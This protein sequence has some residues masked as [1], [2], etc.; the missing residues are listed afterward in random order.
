MKR[1]LIII[2][3]LVGI[4][5]MADA[6]LK[7]KDLE[8]TLTILQAELEQYNNEL[9]RRS[10]MRKERTK[11]LITQLLLTMKQADQNAL[12]LYSQYQENVF[13]MTY[14][15]HEATKLYRDFHKRQIPFTE[16]LEKNGREL[17]RYD[18][19]ISRLEALPEI[20]TTK[21]GTSKRDSCLVL[22]KRIRRMLGESLQATKVL[23][24]KLSAET[25]ANW[26][27]EAI[28]RFMGEGAKEQLYT[29][30]AIQYKQATPGGPYQRSISI[31][32]DP[33]DEPYIAY[34]TNEVCTAVGISN[35]TKA[36]IAQE[37]DTVVKHLMKEA[38]PDGTKG[39]VHIE[40]HTKDDQLQFEITA[41][42]K[43]T[44]ITKQ[45]EKQ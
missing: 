30:F 4:I 33:K 12:M 17:A 15:C 28:G 7:E 27:K 19:L 39:D 36:A 25:F 1:I 8:Q 44:T 38:Y 11:Q 42:D 26:M 40:A 10:T 37:L 3:L 9:S 35:K 2:V 41:N 13:D 14:A 32:N 16:F 29:M 6:V 21:Y 5:S 20:M 43:V 23:K 34:F 31:S 45:I 18:S 22:A 24:E